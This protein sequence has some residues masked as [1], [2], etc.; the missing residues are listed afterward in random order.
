[1]IGLLIGLL[2]D[3]DWITEGD[4]LVAYSVPASWAE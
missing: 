3:I 4:E 2:V 1:M